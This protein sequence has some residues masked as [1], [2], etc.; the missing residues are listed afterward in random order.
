MNLESNDGG[1]VRV[2]KRNTG[3]N[4][5]IQVGGRKPN[6]STSTS[7]SVR[8]CISEAVKM[9]KREVNIMMHCHM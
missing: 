9:L 8:Q 5:T 7:W 4:V 1:G 3:Q 6:S 2:S